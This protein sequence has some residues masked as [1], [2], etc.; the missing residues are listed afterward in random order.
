ME[1]EGFVKVTGGRVWYGIVGRGKKPPVILLHGGPGFTHW[2]MQ[3]LT[4]L[5]DERPVIFDDQLGSGKSDRPQDVSLWTKERFV[6]ELATLRNALDLPQVHLLGHSWGTMLASS[7]LRTQPEGIKSV[8]FSSSCLSARRWADDQ[9]FYRQQL[10]Q[11]V[12]EVLHRCEQS[13]TTDSQEYEWAMQEYYRRHYCR[14]DPWPC[15][16]TQDFEQANM[17]VYHTM[18][19]PAEFYAT[20]NLRD[21]E[22]TP[23]LPYL[24]MPTLFTCGRFDE[25]TPE[26]NKFYSSLVQGSTMHVF[27]KSAH[28]TYLEEPEEYIQVVRDFLNEQD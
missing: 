22:A 21:F 13:G 18:W 17:E 10:P 19:G 7:Y 12:Q 9:E 1:Q 25:S 6:E 3:P 11:A 28:M 15:E 14:L 20:G 4:A 23:D 16:I 26:T 5:S 2:S 27:E 24:N 8:I